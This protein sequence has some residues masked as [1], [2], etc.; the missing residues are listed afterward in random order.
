M[1]LVASEIVRGLANPGRGRGKTIMKRRLPKKRNPPPLGNQMGSPG[2]GLH[3]EMGFSPRRFLW[4]LLTCFVVSC[5]FV[6]L[7]LCFVSHTDLQNAFIPATSITGVLTLLV[8][9]PQLYKKP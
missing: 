3:A 4:W 8:A 2:F 5:V 9:I 6:G 1:D 7:W